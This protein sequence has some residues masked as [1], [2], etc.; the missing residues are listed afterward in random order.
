MTIH[1][2]LDTPPSAA[3]RFLSSASRASSA[4]FGHAVRAVLRQVL[5]DLRATNKEKHARL[6]RALLFVRIES[7]SLLSQNVALLLGQSLR[8]VE[9]QQTLLKVFADIYFVR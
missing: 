6:G 4:G 1:F 7:A 3:G 2:V 5:R 9:F 8:L